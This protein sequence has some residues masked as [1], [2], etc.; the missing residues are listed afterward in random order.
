MAKRQEHLVKARQNEINDQHQTSKFD[1][2]ILR[3][4]LMFCVPMQRLYERVYFDK[5]TLENCF[6]PLDAFNDGT[7]T[8]KQFTQTVVKEVPSLNES[9]ATQL[10]NEFP[11]VMSGDRYNKE[12]RILYRVFQKALDDL[13]RLDLP[14]SSLYERYQ[15]PVIELQQ[16]KKI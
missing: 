12:M 4:K 5:L 1:H 15:P 14:I 2:M 11:F 8:L 9:D 6:M 13:T 10:A 3:E 7:V 16:N